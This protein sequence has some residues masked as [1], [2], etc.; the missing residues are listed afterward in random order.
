LLPD[1]EVD[2]LYLDYGEMFKAMKGKNWVLEPK[3]VEVIGKKAKANIFKT[4][5]G[6]IIP[7][8]FGEEDFVI[9]KIK[10]ITNSNKIEIIHPGESAWKEVKTTRGSLKIP[11]NRGCAMVRI[12]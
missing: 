1:N 4:D 12:N 7:V 3:A 5:S 6:I 10:N 11:L 9:L 2:Q 8:T